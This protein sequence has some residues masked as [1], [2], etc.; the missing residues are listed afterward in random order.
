MLSSRVR[1]GRSIRGLSLP[2]ACTRAERREVEKV[3]VDALSGLTGDLAGRYYRLSEMTENEQQQLIDVS[4]CSSRPAPWCKQCRTPSWHCLSGRLHP[5]F[6]ALLSSSTRS[7]ALARQ[8]KSTVLLSPQEP[9]AFQT[10]PQQL[11]ATSDSCPHSPAHAQRK[12]GLL[13]S[14]GAPPA[15][16]KGWAEHQQPSASQARNARGSCP[17]VPCLGEPW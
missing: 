7:P 15:P 1:T 9:G 4:Q 14:A 6:T 8:P 10:E 16:G 11:M 17:W 3:A 5:L 13:H 2:P 12:A